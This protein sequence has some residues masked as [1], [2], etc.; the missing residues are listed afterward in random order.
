MA[1]NQT[2]SVNPAEEATLTGVLRTAIRK[3]LQQTDGMMPVE[4]VSYDRATNRA[5]V[6]HLVQMQG[7]DGAKVDRA[8]VSS[9]RV[10]QPGNGAFSMSL[11]I[12]PGDKGWL[13]A[14]D[15]DISVF[16]QDVDR[17]DAPNT[18]RMKSFQDGLF[19]PDAM[20]MGDVPAGEG[21]RVVIGSNDGGSILSFDGSGFY[22]TI[23]GVSVAI[24]AAGIEI[25]GGEVRHNGLNIGSTHTHGGIVPGG[26][27]TLV[28][29][30]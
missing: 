15:R 11:P 21:D 4:V 25:T 29:N 23:G 10:L 3:E 20:K 14:A 12:K 28:P 16:Q 9:I 8:Q 6:R 19:M 7:S 22:F 30:A 27:N 5:T 2:P 17:Q 24:T 13:L 1:D 18:A 26:G